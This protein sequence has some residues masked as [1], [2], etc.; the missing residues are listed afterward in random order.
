MNDIATLGLAIDSSQVTTATTAL[1][2]MA[3]AA[4]P[5]TTALAGMQATASSVSTGQLASA[6]ASNTHSESLRGQRMVL[7]GLAGDLALLGPQY[8]QAAAMASLFYIENAHLFQGMGGLRA[9][10]GGLITPT[11]L[12]IGGLAAVAVGGYVA[13]TSIKA[14]ELEF[15]A[16]ADRTDTAVRALHGFESAAAFKG[17]DTSDFLKG[18]EKLGDLSAQA[19]DHMG[20]L[21]EF[22]R[23]N[24]VA[25]GSLNDNLFHAADL[26]KNAASDAARYQ[27]IQQL[28]L[29]ATREWVEY[30]KQGGASLREA[31]DE[32]TKF[33]GA[34]DEQ[35]IAKAR[36]FDEQ[37]NKTWKNFA[38]GA[39]SAFVE[40]LSWLDKFSDSATALLMKI[41]G[42]GAAVPTNLLRAAM[43]AGGQG[44]TQSQAGGFYNA[45]GTSAGGGGSPAKNT[46][47]PNV[48]KNEIGLEQQRIGILGQLATVQDQVTQ[49]KNELTLA[50][51][52]GVNV[53]TKERDALL[54]YT[55]ASAL[56]LIAIRQ[57]TMAQQVE[58]ATVGMG[59]GESAAY[60]AEQDRLNQ[61]RLVGQTLTAK[62]ID[63]LHQEATALGAAAQ[64]AAELKASSDL[65]FS[66]SQF[67]RTDVEGQ[68]ATQLRTLYGDDYLSHMNDAIA[69]QIRFNDVLSQTKTVGEGALSGFMQDLRDSKTLGDALNNVMIKFENKL[70]D[71]ASN[72]IMSGLISGGGDVFSG[73]FSGAGAGIGKVA[74]GVNHTGYGPGDSSPMRFVHPSYFDDAPRFHTGIGPGERAAVIQDTEGVFT[75]GQ[76]RSLAPVGSGSVTVNVM[77]APAG[78]TATATTSSD[79]KGAMRVDVMLARKSDD[80]NAAAIDSGQSATNLSLERRYG[81]TPKLS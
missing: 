20:S 48:L 24:N 46:I 8:G 75:A 29:P 34:A 61:A 28:G 40:S 50:G 19:R 31:V 41:P 60:R 16:L 1:D 56:G 70:F 51:L 35:L 37:W 71:I 14:T 45:V 10:I 68:V 58:S 9:A 67:G 42:L 69:G 18:M 80:M 44:L 38:T 36:E 54:A 47:D 6:A 77:N 62:Q 43:N 74:A 59:V 27:L 33:G 7:R 15:G 78:T 65:A 49:K 2:K 53:T 39:K 57:Q 32:A 64:K 30:L 13:Y 66:T 25:A 26:I 81:L 4:R 79:S 12:L 22:F 55:A 21:A 76:M 5:A 73:L 23:A 17:I 63:L 11:N 3:A 72:K 52:A